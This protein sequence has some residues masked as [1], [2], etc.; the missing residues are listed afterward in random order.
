MCMRKISFYSGFILLVAAAC[1]C[2]SDAAVYAAPAPLCA[3]NV[4]LGVGDVARY[5][6]I[7]GDA[8]NTT[9]V[10]PVS[11]HELSLGLFNPSCKVGYFIRDNLSLGCGVLFTDTTYKWA[12][13][14]ST[15]LAVSP[16]CKFYIPIDDVFT[17]NYIGGLGAE[18][19]KNYGPDFGNAS[20][21]TQ[22]NAI[23]GMSFNYFLFKRVALSLAFDYKVRFGSI[24]GEKER[25]GYESYSVSLNATA[26]LEL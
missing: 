15:P 16:F 20:S 13:E 22:L 8:T 2:V 25:S 14:S 6:I 19:G 5:S 4:E 7:R 18:I 1:C 12:A 23:V 17:I 21:S 26:Y 11:R 9:S 10:K 24:I 3:G